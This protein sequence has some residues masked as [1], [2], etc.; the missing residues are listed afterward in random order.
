VE[1]R[2]REQG[3]TLAIPDDVKEFLLDKGF[4]PRYGARP[5]RRTIQRMVEDRLADLLLAGEAVRGGAVSLGLVDG[6]I[7]FS[8]TTAPA[9]TP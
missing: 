2:A 8:C 3:V 1:R 6:A 5:L 4:D 9:P 7:A